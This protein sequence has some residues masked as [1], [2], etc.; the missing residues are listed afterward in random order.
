MRAVRIFKMIARCSK[1]DF[2]NLWKIWD[3]NMYS[4]KCWSKKKFVEKNR[5]LLVEKTFGT[6][7][8]RFFRET[9]FVEK[10]NENSKFQN[11]ENFPEILKF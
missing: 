4:E 5:K 11:F 3:R 2:W 10:I 8:N 6:K 9:F 1:C 7:K